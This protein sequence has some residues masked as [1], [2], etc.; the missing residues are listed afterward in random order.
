MPANPH[1]QL[2][3][4][5]AAALVVANMIGTGVF[6]TSG[7]TLLIGSRLPCAPKAVSYQFSFS[8]LLRS[9]FPLRGLYARSTLPA[10]KG[11]QANANS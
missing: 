4:G 10:M 7:F 2:R 11:V 3:L 1:R 5:S 8:R 6:T 9:V